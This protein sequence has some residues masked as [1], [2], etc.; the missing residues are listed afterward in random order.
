MN[1]DIVS[2]YKYLPLS[3]IETF[4]FLKNYL[5]Q[6]IWFTPLELSDAHNFLARRIVIKY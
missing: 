3:E 4:S 1:K 5:E 2:F 6:K